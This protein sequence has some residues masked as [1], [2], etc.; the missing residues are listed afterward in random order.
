MYTD[1]TTFTNPATGGL[2]GGGAAYSATLLGGSQFW[3]G[4]QFN[5]GPPNVTNII[6]CAGQTVPLPLG[7]FLTLRLLATGI[8]GNQTSQSLMVTY[9]DSSTTTYV[10]SLSDWFTPQNY[11]GESKAV[12]MGHRNSSNGTQ[13]NRTFYLYGYSFSLNSS[14]TVQSVRLPGNG[15]VIVAAISLV[16]NLAPVFTLNPFSVSSVTAGQAYGGTIATNASDLDGDSLTFAK[17]SGPAWLSVAAN[18]GLSGTPLSADVG[19]NGFVVSVADAGGL[20]NSATMN[21]TVNA[22]PPIFATVSPQPPNLLLN[23]TG[24]IAPYQVQMN[25]DLT[26]SAWV[27]LAGPLS[28]T[29]LL[30]TP[31]NSAAFYR[32][33]GQ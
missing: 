17:V 33:L 2:D 3:N 22:P 6:S 31:S 30:I 19:A 16:P 24:G 9:A 21:L 13:D 18:G 27:G 1:G 29:S 15:N 11:P 5:F 32:I 20:S 4:V 7:N 23:W 28:S 10:Q 25:T 8:Q 26:S 14:K 12:I